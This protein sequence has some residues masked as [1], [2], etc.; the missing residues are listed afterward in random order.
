M[1]RLLCI[2]FA[3]DQALAPKK[4]LKIGFKTVSCTFEYE[5]Y[6]NDSKIISGIFCFGEK[7]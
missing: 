3:S 6:R 7:I 4:L 2:V 5:N 1:A